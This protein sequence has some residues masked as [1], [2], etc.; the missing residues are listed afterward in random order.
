MHI[1]KKPWWFRQTVADLERHEG[2]RQFA[3]PDPLSPLGKKYAARKFNFGYEPG[4]RLL[5]KYGEREADGRPWTVGYGFTKGVTPASS[6]SREQARHKLELVLLEHLPILDRLVPN[7]LELPPIIRT[8]LANL[9]FNLGERR[10]AQFRPTLDLFA[11]GDF[12]GAAGRL[13]NT[14][15]YKQVG[16]RAQELVLRLETLRVDPSFIVP[17]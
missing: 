17:N 16:R 14:L 13:K 4:D 11:R 10:L 7:W 9:A 3:Y 6:I 2:F 12:R 5:A 15:W 8:V 1:F